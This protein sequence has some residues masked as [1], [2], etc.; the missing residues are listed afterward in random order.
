MIKGVAEPDEAGF[1]CAQ[2][3]RFERQR[4]Q[5]IIGLPDCFDRRLVTDGFTGE[6]AADGV[7]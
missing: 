7:G 6:P 3:G 5:E 1:R 2:I 4:F